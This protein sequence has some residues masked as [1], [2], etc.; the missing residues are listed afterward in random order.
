M[1][2]DVRARRGIPHYAAA[3]APL[4]LLVC[5]LVSLPIFFIDLLV[6]EIVSLVVCFSNLMV[7][8]SPPMSIRLFL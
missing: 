1:L 7:Y 3:A 4:T 2:A 8:V 6:I 5:L